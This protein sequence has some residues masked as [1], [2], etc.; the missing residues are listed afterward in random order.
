MTKSTNTEATIKTGIAKSTFILSLALTFFATFV[1][2]TILI[3]F[4][5]INQFHD[6]RSDVVA[7]LK[8]VAIVLKNQ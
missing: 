5:T 4:A 1:A 7:D 3:Y 8:S 6:V 2:T